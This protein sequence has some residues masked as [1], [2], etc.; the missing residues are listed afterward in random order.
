M[1]GSQPQGRRT[2]PGFDLAAHMK[3]LAEDGYTIIEDYMTPAQLAAFR[4]GLAPHLGTYRGRNSFE[5]LTT[6][7][8]YT[9]VGRGK[10]YE[11]TASDPRLLAILDRLLAARLD[12]EVT[13]E[14]GEREVVVS[15]QWSSSPTDR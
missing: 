10:V 12:G 3:R 6:E 2:P 5:G 4:E 9:I 7:R 1:D 11:E 15:G 13:D 8:V 14:A